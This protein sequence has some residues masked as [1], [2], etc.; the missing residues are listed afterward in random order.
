MITT[1]A[2]EADFDT[3]MVRSN[4][5]EIIKTRGPERDELA[6]NCVACRACFECRVETRVV[7]LTAKLRI[8]RVNQKESKQLS[9]H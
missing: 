4:H 2:V 9:S 7:A 8:A 3:A 1:F 6:N 5:F